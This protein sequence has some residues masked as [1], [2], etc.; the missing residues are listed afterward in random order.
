MHMPDPEATAVAV[1][2]GDGGQL[3]TAVRSCALL[4]DGTL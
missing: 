4:H 2:C 1:R 3:R